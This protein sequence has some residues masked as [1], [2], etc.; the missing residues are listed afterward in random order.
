MFLVELIVTNLSE[1]L[2]QR[3]LLIISSLLESSNHLEYYLIWAQSIL[4]IH[5]PNINSLSNVSQLLALEK[6]LRRKYEQLSK[7]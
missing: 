3:L 1:H 4:T 6:S 2:M 7:M 5:G